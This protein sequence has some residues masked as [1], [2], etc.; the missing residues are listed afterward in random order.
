MGPVTAGL[1]IT[2]VAGAAAIAWKR[3]QNAAFQTGSGRVGS[4]TTPEG[5]AAFVVDRGRFVRGLDMNR[6]TS[7]GVLTPHWGVDISAVE[8]T[9]V[10]AVVAGQV[11][12]VG[13]VNGYGNTV[14]ISHRSGGK[15]TL[16]GHLS[17]MNVQVGEVVQGGK[18]IGAVG[19]TTAGPSG[20]APSWGARMGAHLHLEVHPRSEPALG[21]RMQRDDPVAWLRREGIALFGVGA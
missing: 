18:V 6:V 16:Y 5:K 4:Y 11:V 7:A 2:G 9:P 12:R 21:T 20:V 3:Q 1:L 14:M 17:S 19:R 10:H 15:S 8:G 13:P